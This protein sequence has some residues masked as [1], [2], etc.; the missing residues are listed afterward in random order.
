MTDNYA[1]SSTSHRQDEHTKDAVSSAPSGSLSP[2]KPVFYRSTFFQATVLGICSFLAP[3]LWG[4]LSLL[5]A[6]GS[7]STSLVNAANS[8]TFCLMVVTCLLQPALVR[9]IGIR[10]ALA[11]GGAGY[12]VYAA[13]LYLN[14]AYK[15]TWLIV[16]GAA[17]CGISAGV[18]WSTEGAVILAYP[19]RKNQGRYLSYW[20]AYRVLGQVLGGAI[21]LGLNA[22]NANA[23]SVSVQTY[24]VF[25]ILQAL[26]PFAALLLSPPH[27]VQ[28]TDGSP[29]FLEVTG[30]PTSQ[31]TELVKCLFRPK[32]LL[33]L[34]LIWSGTFSE[35]VTGTFN[36]TYFSVRSRALGSFL[37]A[38][39]AIIA[40]CLL[41]AFLDFRRLTINQRAKIA[42]MLV[43]GLQGAYWIYAIVVMN[44]FH[45]RPEKPTFDWSDSSSDWGRGF[46]VY[47]MLQ[48]G[49]NTCYELA[50]FIVSGCSDDPEDIIRLTA[51]IRGVESAGQAVSYGI[52][53]TSL[54]LDAV[55][56]I[57]MGLWVIA[58]IPAWLVVRKLGI[59]PDGTHIHQY[60]I[61]AR[62]EQ[63]KELVD[64][65]LAVAAPDQKGA[66]VD[67]SDAVRATSRL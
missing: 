48:I 44:N 36:A 6:G 49:F 22:N 43:Y 11:F 33:L 31:I 4:G 41:G 58:I 59:T 55:A 3:G 17:C 18:F 29:V 30:S 10:Y 40:N 42:Y 2:K 24:L 47:L 16:F 27:K 60:A 62:S 12:S 35:A 53:S 54:R 45:N 52:N 46:G 5:G 56:G 26:A 7:Q 14:S 61:Y 9:L 13:G 21:N 66:E 34:P 64:Q 32:I 37:A 39:L 51:I 67:A 38:I 25:V 50:Y 1:S 23:G 28:R 15:V 8:L 20:L 19:E 65:G 63:R 57:N